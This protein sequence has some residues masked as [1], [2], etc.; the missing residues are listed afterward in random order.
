ME[1]ALIKSIITIDYVWVS[2]FDE[3]EDPYKALQKAHR[4]TACGDG[5]GDG[6]G[7]GH[8]HGHAYIHIT[9]KNEIIIQQII[10]H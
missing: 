2:F 4:P 9:T 10:L 5:D 7:H 1:M 3:I 8:G 6:H